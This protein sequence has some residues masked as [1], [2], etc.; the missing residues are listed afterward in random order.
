MENPTKGE[1]LH[2]HILSVWLFCPSDDVLIQTLS[3]LDVAFA[4]EEHVVRTELHFVS[5]LGRSFHSIAGYQKV[6]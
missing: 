2:I 4:K 6:G 5:C 1:D 3:S